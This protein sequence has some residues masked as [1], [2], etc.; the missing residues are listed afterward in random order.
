[1]KNVRGRI[2]T[3]LTLAGLWSVALPTVAQT[4]PRPGTSVLKNPNPPAPP[5]FGWWDQSAARASD[6]NA[7]SAKATIAYSKA[8][9]QLV[10]RLKLNDQSASPQFDAYTY[11]LAAIPAGTLLHLSYTLSGD[12]SQPKA[13]NRPTVIT[14]ISVFGKTGGSHDIVFSPSA[15]GAP[16]QKGA[17]PLTGHFGPLSVSAVFAQPANAEQVKVLNTVT[18]AVGTAQIAGLSLTVA[19]AGLTANVA[20]AADF[21]S[22]AQADASYL[23][24]YNADWAAAKASL[25]I[26][27]PDKIYTPQAALGGPHPRYLFAGLPVTVLKRRLASPA[28]AAY[29]ADLFKT[30]DKY[31]GAPPPAKP[32][33]NAEDPLRDYSDRTAWIALAYVLTDDPA[34]KAACLKAAVAYVDAYTA[35]GLPQHDLPLSQMILGM[36]ALYDWMYADLPAATRAKARQHIIDCARWM[37]DPQDVSALQWRGNGNWLANH[38]WFNYA[39]LAMAASVLWGDTSAPLQPGETKLWMDEAMQVFWVVRKTFG[40]DGAPVEGYLYQSY[41]LRP[42]LDFAALADQLTT[43]TAFLDTPGLRNIGVSR[44][45]SLLPNGA[46]FF[47]YADSEPKEWGGS[48]YF[49]LIA[50]RFRDPKAQLLADI[51]ENDE[52]R[53]D[54]VTENY[55]PGLPAYKA[56]APAPTPGGEPLVLEAETFTQSPNA[57]VTGPKFGSHGAAIKAWD[58]ANTQIE[59]TFTVARAGNYQILLKYAAGGPASRALMIDGKVPFREAGYVPFLPTGGWSTDSN[60]WRFV[61]AGEEVPGQKTP[62]LFPLTAGTHTLTIRNDTGNGVNL[63]WVAFVPAGMAKDAV[64]AKAGDIDA[65]VAAPTA[66]ATRD[67]HGLFWYDP[68]VPSA[69]LSAEPL[70]RDNDDLGIYVAR[71]SWTDP[72]A[73]LMGFKAG[74]VA[75]KG[76]L[77]SIPGLWSG[78]SQPD[79]GMFE[80]YYGSH[81]VVSGSDYTHHRLTTDHPVVV[82]EGNDPN[83]N[84]GQLIGQYGEGSQWFSN[85][86]KFIRTSATTVWTAH[87]P[88]YHTYMA[89][90]GGVYQP[91]GGNNKASRDANT[92]SLYRRSITYLP[93]GVVVVVDRVEAPTPQTFRFRIPTQAKDMAVSGRVW[94]FK[95]GR[96]PGR[97]VDVSPQA[98]EASVTHEPVDSYRN[99]GSDPAARN[100]ATLRAVGQTSAIFAVVLGMNGAER[101]IT[102][103]ASGE[104]IVIRGGP[105]GPIPLDWMPQARPPAAHPMAGP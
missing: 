80:F 40:S 4:A 57:G 55:D 101:G 9:G 11:S 91:A 13:N 75:G 59:K 24:K 27:D 15:T 67:W 54:D 100:V 26:P 7:A 30:A 71:S 21:P 43:G 98:Y 89:D 63:D 5:D 25:G 83:R 90:L 86:Y 93:Q 31:A 17:A 58:V 82:L 16:V 10:A 84:Q 64:I 96:T 53:G 88:N 1:M 74:P 51:M 104:G 77:K 46:G 18:N 97:I 41:G 70:F 85:A 8:D 22:A 50:S 38:K 47:V 48:E 81:A 95:I 102:V 79:E 3:G 49:R 68:A 52:A 19:E 62:W 94:T 33:M 34:K 28:Y 56:P 69:T 20:P 99:P 78:H 32:D 36:G 39:G 92:M 2:L 23:E 66:D 61:Y 60:Q 103:Q 44:L 73:T 12:L 65:H 29:A 87:T 37:R 76:V 45:H 42:Y 105:G 72:R 35:W 14:T 6:P